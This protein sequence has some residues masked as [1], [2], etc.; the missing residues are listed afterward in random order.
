MATRLY[1]AEFQTI[2]TGL[3][4]DDKAIEFLEDFYLDFHETYYYLDE[5][6]LGETILG[7]KESGKEPPQ[8]LVDLL[9]KELKENGELTFVIS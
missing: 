8:E 4:L 6:M 7:W 5:D 3:I 1:K 2:P 9:Y